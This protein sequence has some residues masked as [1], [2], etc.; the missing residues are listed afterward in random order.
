VYQ[1]PQKVVLPLIEDRIIIPWYVPILDYFKKVYIITR[2]KILY[3]LLMILISFATGSIL[4]DLFKTLN[5]LG[6]GD[7]LPSEIDV[8]APYPKEDL[9]NK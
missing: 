8:S 2:G 6:N 7:Y 1:E 5:V 4:V 3:H 9:E